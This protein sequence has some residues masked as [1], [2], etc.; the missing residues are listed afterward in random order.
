[1]VQV[2]RGDHAVFL[3]AFVVVAGDNPRDGLPAD[4]PVVLDSHKALHHRYGACAECLYL[5]R[6]DG[7][8][9]YRCQPA[10]GDKLNAYLSALLKG[11]VHSL[12]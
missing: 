3:R 8:I 2:A 9:G 11:D 5:I 10:D 1:M 4:F 6:P 7:Y 12:P